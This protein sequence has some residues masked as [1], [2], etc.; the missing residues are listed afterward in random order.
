MSCPLESNTSF[1]S[2]N[3]FDNKAHIQ[4]D[5]NLD[6]AHSLVRPNIYIGAHYCAKFDDEAFEHVNNFKEFLT[7]KAPRRAEALE[8]SNKILDNYFKRLPR[9]GIAWEKYGSYPYNF[10]ASE[11]EVTG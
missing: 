3:P 6:W 2:H 4:R 11:G 1:G 7:D 8:N 9:I 5:L 10:Y